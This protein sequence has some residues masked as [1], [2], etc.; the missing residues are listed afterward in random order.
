MATRQGL[1]VRRG[2]GADQKP[3]VDVCEHRDTGPA[4]GQEHPRE[5][6]VLHCLRGIAVGLDEDGVAGRPSGARKQQMRDL[7]VAAHLGGV[8]R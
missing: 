5:S 7:Q 2:D 8:W 4:G 1:R 3:R 6:V